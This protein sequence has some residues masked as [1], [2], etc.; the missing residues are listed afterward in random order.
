[1]KMSTYDSAQPHLLV[2][3][4][5][6]LRQGL[7][8]ALILLLFFYSA[9]AQTGELDPVGAS[10]TEDVSA[11][12]KS[13][14]K[15]DAQV[16]GYIQ[17]HFNQ[18]ID[19]NSNGAAPNRFR[20]QRARVTFE[21]KV[22]ERVSY[23]MDIDPRSPQVTG[24]MRDAYVDIKLSAK[25]RLRAGQQ[26]VKF[27]YINQRSSSSL[28]TVNRPEMA[29]ELSRGINL[30]DIGVSLL[31][32]MP[33]R[34]ATHF[35]YAVSVVN[36]AGINAQQDNNKK[37][38]VSG[39]IGLF[40]ED[41]NG[42][43]QFGFSAAVG[44]MFETSNNPL[45]DGGYFRDFQRVGTDFLIE[46]SRFAINGEYAVGK[47]EEKER[48]REE[49]VHGY[50]LTLVGKTHEA[51]GPILSYDGIDADGRITLGG[52]YGKPT[53]VFRLLLNY[54]KRTSDDRLYLWMLTRF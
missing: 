32:E 22:N 7:M 6:A 13:K 11:P 3:T 12:T 30:R 54:E 23:E 16:K 50:Y 35:E 9:E 36:G 19:T 40:N 21:G 45:Y 26:K 18:P 25:H 48:D 51:M 31:G 14:K 53:D 46:R 41:E 43:W 24:L 8:S 49:T 37:K 5:T 1:M 2:H 29:D 42:E 34:S 28:Y 44:D 52:Y 27:G 47:H 15:K 33:M 4:S 17:F 20:V 10:G 39:R 38:N